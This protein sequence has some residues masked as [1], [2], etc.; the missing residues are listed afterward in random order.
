MSI[1]HKAAC[2]QCNARAATFQRG[3]GTYQYPMSWIRVEWQEH[4]RREGWLC[5]WKCVLRYG[6]ERE[7]D[8]AG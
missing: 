8:A 6:V 4:T 5:S 2:D 7:N 3:D 1:V